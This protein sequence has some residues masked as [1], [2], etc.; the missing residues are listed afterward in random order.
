MN[1]EGDPEIAAPD[2]QGG[3]AQGAVVPSTPGVNSQGEEIREKTQPD[4]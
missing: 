4:G 1:I 3:S 2:N